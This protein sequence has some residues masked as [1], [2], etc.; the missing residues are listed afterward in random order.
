M[1][2]VSGVVHT[3]SLTPQ[4]GQRPAGDP[5][6]CSP[7]WR[8]IRGE[9]PIAPFALIG[10]AGSGN[11]WSKRSPATARRGAAEEPRR[12]HDRPS[13]KDAVKAAIMCED[14]ARRWHRRILG[15]PD[16]IR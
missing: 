6:L 1:P 2:E 3:H 15:S 13:A 9:I 4:R 11:S 10:D 7:R 14:A 16:H 12:L 8:R 5:V